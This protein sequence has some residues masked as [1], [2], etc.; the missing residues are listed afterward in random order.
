[1]ITEISIAHLGII[2]QAT[3]APGRHLTVL[4]GET[5]AGKTM[6]L[7]AVGML[8]GGKISPSLLKPDERTRVEGCW[9]VTSADV[10]AAVADIGG[11]VED[12]ELILAR[13]ASGAGRA[14]AFVGGAG[15]P[16]TALA[17]I[18]GSLVAVHGQSDQ[19]RLRSSA[20]QRRLLDAFGGSELGTLLGEYQRLF[21]EL[22]AVSAE[23]TTR[24]TD[25]RARSAR[26]DFLRFALDEIAAVDPKPGEDDALAAE[27]ERLA[28]VGEL[29]ELCEAAR[30]ALS[31]DTGDDAA[32]G[33]DAITRV[34]SAVRAVT[35]ASRHDTALTRV[36]E[37]LH[38]AMATLADASA[39]LG[40]YTAGLESDPR[41]LAWVQERRA[42]L[43]RLQR[44][45]GDTMAEVLAWAQQS[46][47]EVADLDTDTDR[48]AHLRAELERLRTHLGAAGEH[49]STARAEAGARLAAAVTTEL[50]DLA[51]PQAQFGVTLRATDD[52]R[53]VPV[54]GRT[55]AFGPDGVD[56]VAFQLQP[57]P[58]VAAAPLGT[59]ASGGELSRVMLALEVAAAGSDAVPTMIFDEV[60]AGVGGRAAVEIGRRLN[61]L[62]AHTQVLVVTHLPQVAAFADTHL[63][64]SK[65]SD[66]RVTTTSVVPVTGEERRRE[67]ARMLAGQQDSSHA[68]AHADELLAMGALESAAR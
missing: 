1:M 7:S 54:A 6:V 38:S 51:M 27:A 24:V 12:E 42:T 19:L 8:L 4:T 65:D 53:G 35:R 13:T 28:N 59:G 15:V 56:T 23:L 45:Y 58:G 30:M 25:A 57:H 44:K 64:V 9:Q 20:R 39:E 37:Q 47:A 43:T 46:A 55:V 31:G 3:V 68:L 34:D 66:G 50:H 17:G 11:V 29:S 52:P 10:A 16:A 2:E 60:D 14:R 63:V 22:S 62:A 40:A 49:L 26:A 61:R 48:I 5:G 33:D 36:A 18:A 41:R 67:I 21:G 32:A